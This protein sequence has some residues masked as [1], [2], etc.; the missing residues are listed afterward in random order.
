M[1]ERMSDTTPKIYGN[2]N[3][4]TMGTDSCS[5]LDTPS[6]GMGDGGP[7]SL[8]NRMLSL[9]I[10]VAKDLCNM[11]SLPHVICWEHG[12]EGGQAVTTKDRARGGARRLSV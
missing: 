10:C 1:A 6:L 3:E 11:L 9:L 4:G 5:K 8:A 7:P 2:S 12:V